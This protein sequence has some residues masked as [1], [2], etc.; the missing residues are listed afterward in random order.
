M[1][2]REDPIPSALIGGAAHLPILP[3]VMAGGSGTRLWPLS[4]AGY[5]K[6]LLSFDGARSLLLDT[7]SRTRA[8]AQ[9]GDPVIVC[10]ADH[11]LAVAD[12]LRI[13]G[14]QVGTILLEQTGRNTAAALTVAA[15]HAQ[16]AD[17]PLLLVLPADHQ[18]TDEAAFASGVEMGIAA[19]TAGDIILFGVVPTTADSNF[20]YIRAA[21]APPPA[22]V[23]SFVEKPD[24]ES[25]RKMLLTGDCFWNSGM[26]LVRA[27]TWL[28]EVAEHA[29][30]VLV[31]C[32]SAWRD[33]VASTDGSVRLG[34]AGYSACPDL[35]LDRAVLERTRRARVVPLAAGW[36]DLGTWPSVWEVAGKDGAGNVCR[37]DVMAEESTGCYLSSDRQLLVA[38]GLQDC[39]VVESGDAVLVASRE[40]AHRVAQVVARL[41]EQKRPETIWPRRCQRPWGHYEILAVG[42]GFKLK[43]LT[44]DPGAALSRQLH[45]HRAED[46]VVVSGVGQVERGDEVLLISENDSAR[47]P[48]GVVHRLMNPGAVP[49]QVIE[50]QSG[51]YLEEDDITRIEDE[52]GR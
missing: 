25:A 13:H 42:Q 39:I 26:L 9:C 48:A 27:S 51:G 22:A 45:Q 40:S 32:R 38:V 37:G 52:Y 1:F 2:H 35:S 33:A 46:W 28:A 12:Q 14:F 7:L 34:A 50:V 17:D 44:V 18:I 29:P 4:R 21:A 47:I 19:A 20:G 30:E 5:P 16:S 43:L 8:L 31:A 3:V 36:F 24:R 49:L 15:L 11:Q 10:H 6:Y 41:A 23:C